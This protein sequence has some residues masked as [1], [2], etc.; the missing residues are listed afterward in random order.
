MHEISWIAV[1]NKQKCLF[2]KTE[3]KKVK[4]ILSGGLVSVG[5]ERI[6]QKGVEG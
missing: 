1:F 2:S 5:V 6:K 4:R 3:D